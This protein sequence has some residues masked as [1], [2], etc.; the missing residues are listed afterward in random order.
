MGSVRESLDEV[1]SEA[2]SAT[3]QSVSDDDLAASFN[4][5]LGQVSSSGSPEEPL[6]GTS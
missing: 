2:S 1:D 3:F 5:R 6:T 4:S